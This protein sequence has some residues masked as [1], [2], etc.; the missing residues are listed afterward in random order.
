LRVACLDTFGK[1]KGCRR[2]HM[3]LKHGIM[4]NAAEM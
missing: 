3:A 2:C 4:D 1:W